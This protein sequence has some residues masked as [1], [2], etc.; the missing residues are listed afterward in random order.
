MA[1]EA[2]EEEIRAAYLRKIKEYPPDR[3]PDEFER[4]RDAYE[5]LRDPRTRTRNMLFGG[6]R[7][8]PLDHLLDGRQDGR[9]FAG[10]KLWLAALKEK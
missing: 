5:V 6:E 4:V 2:G 10:L 9:R 3:A 1:A 8:A 7:L